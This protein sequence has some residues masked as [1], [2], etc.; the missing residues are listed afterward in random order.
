[1]GQN[2]IRGGVMCEYSLAEL[3]TPFPTELV[4]N[5]KLQAKIRKEFTS[6]SVNNA[7]RVVCVVLDDDPTGTQSVVDVPV[8]TNWSEESFI[9]AFNTGKPAIYISTNTRSYLPKQVN[10]ITSQAFRNAFN[11]A[12]KCGVI[13]RW[14][15]R[16]DS[17]LRG[18]FPLEPEILASEYFQLTGSEFDATIVIPAYTHAGRIT[19]GGTHYVQTS[20]NSFI[21]VSESQFA[22]DKTFGYK[23]SFL[24]DWIAE[25]TSGRVSSSEVELFDLN[26]IR[27]KYTD[28]LKRLLAL[29]NGKYA[30]FDTVTDVDLQI[31]ALALSQAEQQGA[32]FLY[33]VG[34]SFIRARIGQ[35]VY[36]PLSNVDIFNNGVLSANLSYSEVIGGL[37]VVGSHVSV[38]TRQLAY[39]RQNKNIREFTFA[40]AD[41]LTAK[42]VSAY[43]KNFAQKVI[44]YLQQEN[45]VIST[46]REVVAGADPAKSLEIAKQISQGLSEMV[47]EIVKLQTPRFIVAK[48]GITSA[49]I[50]T[51]GL[52]ANRA[53]VRGTLLPEAVA[54]W[55]VQDGLV[56]NLPYVVF[57]GNVGKESALVEVLEKLA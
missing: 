52:Q 54:L 22:K 10:E 40:V 35:D 44:P 23:N 11:A 13:P 16:S 43:C 48:G 14:V 49:D 50:L 45:V 51:D 31:I 2:Y 27:G 56:P 21:P 37:V 53:F 42:D 7:Q 57:A 12:K 29:N 33:R 32:K 25:K 8:I 3:L 18:H 28:F 1:M 4:F 26:I 6:S 17:T 20:N 41:F 39:L 15:S 38:T 47:K 46:S 19:V 34:P 30:V 55:Q 5:A 9:W 24:P 36:Q